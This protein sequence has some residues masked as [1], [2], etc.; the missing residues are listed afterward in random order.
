MF[1]PRRCRGRAELAGGILSLMVLG[2]RSDGAPRTVAHQSDRDV[3]LGLLLAWWGPT[4][5]SGVA[6]FSFGGSSSPTHGLRLVAMACRLA[7]IIANLE[8]K[9]I[10]DLHQEGE[11]PVALLQ[12]SRIVASILRYG[13][14]LVLVILPGGGALLASFAA[15]TGEKILEE[16]RELRQGAIQGVGA[17]NPANNAGARLPL[18]L[19]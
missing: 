11:Q 2:C 7:E 1:A 18:S 14:G 16:L 17:R 12:D 13:S 4:S 10:A 19:C 6:R 9:S 5:N 15:Y 3:I 8:Q